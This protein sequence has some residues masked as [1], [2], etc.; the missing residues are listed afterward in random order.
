MTNI[1]ASNSGGSF[2]IIRLLLIIVELFL[3]AMV[4]ILGAAFVMSL[5]GANPD[6]GFASWIYGRTEAIMKPFDGIFSPITITDSTKVNTSLLF[7]M[8]VYAVLAAV[9]EGVSRRF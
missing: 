9:V 4:L 7:A 1:E 3:A 8:G 5:L 2:G 6:A